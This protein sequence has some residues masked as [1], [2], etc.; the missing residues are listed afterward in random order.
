MWFYG[1]A[2]EKGGWMSGGPTG[3]W[4]FNITRCPCMCEGWREG[5]RVRTWPGCQSSWGF[6]LWS[7]VPLSCQLFFHLLPFLPILS[8][9][10]TFKCGQSVFQSESLC[11]CPI[12]WHHSCLFA[13][14]CWSLKIG[15]PLDNYSDL[16]FLPAS[17][18]IYCI[19][20]ENSPQ[21]DTGVY[22]KQIK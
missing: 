4:K 9:F 21:S 11:P 10:S 7:H 14:V 8:F 18:F 5:T 22:L 20:S 13:R 17:L 16:I 1:R 15:Q 12:P 6:C 19:L 3:A 2:E